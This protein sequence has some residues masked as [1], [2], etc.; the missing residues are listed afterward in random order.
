MVGRWIVSICTVLVVSS[1][2][3]NAQTD[4]TVSRALHARKAYVRAL[5]RMNDALRDAKQSAHVQITMLDRAIAH[6]RA[7]DPKFANYRERSA[8]RL[9]FLVGV[10]E[11]LR[12]HFGDLEQALARRIRELRS[13]RRS[14]NEWIRTFGIFRACPIRGPHVVADNFGY[15][16]QKRPGVPRHA[17][18]GNDITAAYGAPILAPF[19]GHATA[20]TNTLGGLAVTIYGSSGYAYNA[21]LSSYG[22][23]GEVRTG[24]VIGYVG[25]T[26]DATGPHDHFEWHPGNGTAIDPHPYLMAACS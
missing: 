15:V 7:Q 20:S 5:S 11:N 2:A 1:V 21:H 19:E 24:E 4:L 18:Q 22:Q 9:R 17:H 8:S 6:H 14:V 12:T 26:G 16:V 3:A 23:L 25:A 10:R 13:R